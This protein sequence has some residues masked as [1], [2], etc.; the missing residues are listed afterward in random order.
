MIELRFCECI[1]LCISLLQGDVLCVAEDACE[2]QQSAGEK[3]RAFDDDS[4][5]NGDEDE[6]SSHKQS[7]SENDRLIERRS[8]VHHHG[9]EAQRVPGCT[10][11]CTQ[12]PDTRC[13]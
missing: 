9:D 2:Q 5:S 12:Q 11:N 3:R 7:S 10:V 8:S 6:E 1:L 13:Y 4:V